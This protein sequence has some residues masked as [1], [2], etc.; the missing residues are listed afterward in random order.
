MREPIIRLIVIIVAAYA[1]SAI[2]K[3]FKS[4]K[5]KGGAGEKIVSLILSRLNSDKYK[6]VNNVILKNPGGTSQIDHIVVSNYGVFVIE[7]KNYKGHIYGKEQDKFWTQG[8]YKRKEKLYNPIRQNYGH[9][10]ALKE[11]LGEDG[12]IRIIPVVVF[13]INTTLKIKTTSHVVYSVNLLK[14]IKKYHQELISDEKREQIYSKIVSFNRTGKDVRKQ[15]VNGIHKAKRERAEKV[16]QSIC[17]RCRG[18]LVARRGKHGA[19]RGCSNYPR[20]RFTSSV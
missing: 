20:C 17:P 18:S 10:Q 3:V 2:I 19:F 11:R 15:H 14:T 9:V 13:S 1:I 7:S 6:V 5:F 12:D 4:A 16:K 8:I